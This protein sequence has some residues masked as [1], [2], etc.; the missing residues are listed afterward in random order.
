MI[1]FAAIFGVDGA[2]KSL[3]GG[4][5]GFWVNFKDSISFIRPTEF[6]RYKIELPRPSLCEPLDFG[7]M[8][9][10]SI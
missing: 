4:T 9:N 2:Q 3:I 5:K 7:N 1:H 6:V 8:F 10:C